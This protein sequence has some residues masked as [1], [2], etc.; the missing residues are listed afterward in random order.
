DRP[1]ERVQCG[2]EQPTDHK[3]GGYYRL[4]PLYFKVRKAR[5]AIAAGLLIAILDVNET[6]G[7]KGY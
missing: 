5:C 1:A 7:S 3:P 4:V 2:G 6:T